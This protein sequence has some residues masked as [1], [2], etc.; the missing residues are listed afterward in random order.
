M[1]V[2]LDSLKTAISKNT[3][4]SSLFKKVI[5]SFLTNKVKTLTM[6]ILMFLLPRLALTLLYTIIKKKL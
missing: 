4:N 5:A 3:L 2:S 6:L 1:N